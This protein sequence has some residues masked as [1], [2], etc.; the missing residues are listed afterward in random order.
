MKSIADERLSE[1]HRIVDEL[2]DAS[3]RCEAVGQLES[4]EELLELARYYN[5]D[6]GLAVPRAIID[7]PGCDRGL[8]L[9]LFQLAEGIVW[10]TSDEDWKYQE[11]WAGFCR[12]LADRVQIGH[13]PS[14]TIP[15]ESELSKVQRFKAKKDG[16]PDIFLDSAYP[17]PTKS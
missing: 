5:W 15:F 9:H 10:L 8:A 14:L 16:V 12:E 7:H 17:E 11:E 13:Y 3:Q 4:T 1:V 6:D 2:E